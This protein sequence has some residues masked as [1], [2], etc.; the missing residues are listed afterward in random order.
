MSDG[1]ALSGV[2]GMRLLLVGLSIGA[3]AIAPSALAN[4]ANEFSSSG[5]IS[6]PV[7]GA[8]ITSADPED[9][10]EAH[11]REAYERFGPLGVV[12]LGMDRHEIIVLC[13][14]VA[15][16][17]ATIAAEEADQDRRIG[18]FAEVWRLEQ[19]LAA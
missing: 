15:Q 4:N 10:F 5:A 6:E 18:K 9:E 2:Y 8:H 19:R 12:T 16:S 17:F 7:G 11:Q 1:K 14:T 3:L 13:H